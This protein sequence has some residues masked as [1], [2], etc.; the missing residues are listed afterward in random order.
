MRLLRM[1]IPG[2]RIDHAR[3]VDDIAASTKLDGRVV[4]L[5]LVH[6]Q[7]PDQYSAADVD[8][9][10]RLT[11]L[12]RLI[13]CYGSWCEADGRSRDIWPPAARVPLQRLS[14]RIRLELKVL[15]GELPPLPLTAGRDETFVFDADLPETI[16]ASFPCASVI[17]PDPAYREFLSNWLSERTGISDTNEAAHSPKVTVWDADPWNG[18]TAERL[19]AFRRTNPSLAILALTSDPQP[20]EAAMRFCGADVVAS[21]LCSLV[22]LGH[23]LGEAVSI[24]RVRTASAV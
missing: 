9:L 21:K 18:I 4:D 23:R 24:H 12:S 16:S 13:C 11:P 2:V 15:R 22:D 10:L 7:W 20:C 3:C 1:G 5:L 6:Q 19:R 14:T 8:R 17:S